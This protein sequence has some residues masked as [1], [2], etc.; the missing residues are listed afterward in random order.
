MAPV[1]PTKI[2]AMME[3]SVLQ[4]NVKESTDLWNNSLLIANNTSISQ[5]I[6]QIPLNYGE[7]SRDRASQSALE[8]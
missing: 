2:D 7:S 4:N 5:N 3:V 8:M 1:L 6:S